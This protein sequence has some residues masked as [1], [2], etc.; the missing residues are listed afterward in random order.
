MIANKQDP[1]TYNFLDLSDSVTRAKSGSHLL[2]HSACW[3]S[4]V[5]RKVRRREEAPGETCTKRH[6]S[7][8]QAHSLH[9][10]DLINSSSPTA[11]WII[12]RV[13]IWR[14]IFCEPTFCCCWIRYKQWGRQYCRQ[15]KW[16]EQIIS[17]TRFSSHLISI[18]AKWHVFLNTP[19]LYSLE[20]F[21]QVVISEWLC[22]CSNI[23][24]LLL[25]IRS[26][27]ALLL[28]TCNWPLVVHYFITYFLLIFLS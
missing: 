18:S 9:G 12:D 23:I 17:K 7:W 14:N 26:K 2:L 19:F 4:R 25:N 8:P 10:V 20:Q 3:T 24:F 5:F 1:P 15:W 28:F 13:G 16:S 22:P 21:W 6:R 27:L 11:A